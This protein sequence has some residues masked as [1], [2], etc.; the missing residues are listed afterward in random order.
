MTNNLSKWKETLF[1]TETKSETYCIVMLLTHVE[2]YVLMN[3][4]LLIP[5]FS[6]ACSAFC[7]RYTIVACILVYKFVPQTLVHENQ[8]KAGLLSG[9][10]FAIDESPVAVYNISNR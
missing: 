1:G 2:C 8:N 3:L 6:A 7:V 5:V 10:C 4:G 9:S